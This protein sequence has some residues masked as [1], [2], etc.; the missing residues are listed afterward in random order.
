M[1]TVFLAL[2]AWR[3]SRSHVLTRRMPA[4]ETLGAAT[5]LCVDKTGTLTLNQMTLR[6][7]WRRRRARSTSPTLAVDLPEELHALLENAILASKRDPFDP[8]ERALHAAGERLLDADRAPA[9]GLVAGAGVPAEPRAAR[10]EPGVETR[11]GRRRGGRVQ[12]RARGD[13]RPLPPD[14]RASARRCSREVAAL[15]SA[16]AAGA[17]RGARSGESGRPA[18]RAPRPDARVR[19][20]CSASRTRS[21]RPC[22]RPSPSA[23]PPASA[24]S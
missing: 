16:R 21:G 13:R 23:G 14:R 11:D 18:R 24:W 4:V 2:G 19:R 22:R 12:G 1:L 10:R 15:A 3:I 17:R 7:L 20:A 6:R 8:M 5:V 9:S